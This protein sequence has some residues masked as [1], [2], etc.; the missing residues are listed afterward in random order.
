MT[1]WIGI[2][3]G[4]A[5]GVS[6]EVA[7]KAVAAEAA[8]DDSKYLLAGDEHCLRRL[9]RKFVLNLPLETFSD[10]NAAGKLFIAN[11]LA[12]PLPEDLPAGSPVAL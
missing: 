2:S 3:L 6:P 7:L 9:I 10:Y 12:Q 11:P 4:D 5:T 8:K 1:G